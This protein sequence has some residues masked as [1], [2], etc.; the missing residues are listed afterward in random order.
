MKRFDFKVATV[1]IFFIAIKGLLNM[2]LPVDATQPCSRSC[3]QGTG[4]QNENGGWG[5][6]S[7]LKIH[8]GGWHL[9]SRNSTGVLFCAFWIFFI[10]H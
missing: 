6:E 9:T 2:R 8:P 1:I 4:L 7:S 3:K 5:E 10:Y